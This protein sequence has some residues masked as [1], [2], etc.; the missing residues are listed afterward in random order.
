MAEKKAQK[1]S[2]KN[3][4][5]KI[6]GFFK[7]LK[8]EIRKIAWPGAKQTFKQTMVVV[9]ISAIMCGFIRLIDVAATFLVGALSQIF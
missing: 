1:D 7:G 5:Q 3:F 6:G 8:S 4:F 2:E 9:V